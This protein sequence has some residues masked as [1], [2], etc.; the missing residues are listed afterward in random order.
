MQKLL[1]YNWFILAVLSFLV[2]IYIA[3]FESFISDKGYLY[4]VLAL[5]FAIL[6]YR[7]RALI[8]G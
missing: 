5:L 4:L 3:I 2:A 8:K 6:F 1:V 7:K